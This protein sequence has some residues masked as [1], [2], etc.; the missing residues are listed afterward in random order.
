MGVLSKLPGRFMR[1]PLE[2]VSSLI[3][4]AL[5]HRGAGDVESLEEVSAVDLERI[6]PRAARER[7]LE[8]RHVAAYAVVRKPDL[9]VAS[10]DDRALS[11]EL[12]QAVQRLAQC[13]AR[14]LLVHL[15]PKQPDHRVA[16]VE[17]SRCAGGE[18]G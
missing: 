8:E 10:G 12:S 15:T 6:F 9:L 7:F 1:L 4:P 13:A 14:P 11:K 2:V 18:K 5:E 17:T 3:E 16:A